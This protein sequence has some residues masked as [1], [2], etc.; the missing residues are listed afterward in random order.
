MN[1][2]L[3][4]S[5]SVAPWSCAGR[6]RHSSHAASSVPFP[7][8]L[9]MN[10]VFLLFFKGGEK[11]RSAN[12]GSASEFAC[13]GSGRSA[14][15]CCGSDRDW[16]WRGKNWKGSVWRGRGLRESESVLSRYRVHLKTCQSVTVMSAV[17]Q[18]RGCTA[19]FTGF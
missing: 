16:R 2:W 12:V 17:L 18:G 14:R 19:A 11:S 13:C 7:V 10:D 1:G 8:L 9:K 15:T 6:L 4:W 5:A 3:A